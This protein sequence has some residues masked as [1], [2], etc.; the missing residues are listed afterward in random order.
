MDGCPLSSRLLFFRF[1]AGAL[2]D[3]LADGLGSA[4][5]FGCNGFLVPL[6]QPVHGKKGNKCQWKTDNDSSQGHGAEN[7][8]GF[9]NQL[10]HRYLS[11]R[12]LIA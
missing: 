4:L 12:Q 11:E 1:F 8:R 5:K 3:F 7:A 9:L 10:D 6:E 2:F